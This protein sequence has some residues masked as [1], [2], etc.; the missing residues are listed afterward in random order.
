MLE[1]LPQIEEAGLNS[2]YMGRVMAAKAVLPFMGIKKIIPYCL[3]II[4]TS[5]A[6]TSNNLLHYKLVTCLQLL[7]SLQDIARTHHYQPTLDQ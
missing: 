4:E 6:I 2:N 3:N 7:T 5:G 1:L